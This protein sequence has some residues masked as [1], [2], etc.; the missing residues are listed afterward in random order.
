MVIVVPRSGFENL[1]D[2][3]ANAGYTFASDDSIFLQISEISKNFIGISV[4]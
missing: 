1:Y 3:I 4:E 2:E